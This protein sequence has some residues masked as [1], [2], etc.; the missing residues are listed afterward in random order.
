MSKV[1]LISRTEGVGIYKDL[2]NGEI[3]A[4][5]ARHGT[6]KEDNEKLIKYLMD[7]KYWKKSYQMFSSRYIGEVASKIK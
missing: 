7:N 5:I 4:A 3:I 1:E 2:S 6:I